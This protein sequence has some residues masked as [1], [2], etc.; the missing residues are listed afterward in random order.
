MTGQLQL[1]EI[2]KTFVC[3]KCGKADT[4][5][6]RGRT[7]KFC[8]ECVDN[9]AYTNYVCTCSRCGMT[10]E[11][12]S[13]NTHYCSDVCRNRCPDCGEPS[14]GPTSKCLKCRPDAVENCLHCEAP[15]EYAGVGRPPL[16]CNRT[17]ADR[18]RGDRTRKIYPDECCPWCFK[19]FAYTPH[20][21][22]C[23]NECKK[24]AFNHV[25]QHRTIDRCHLVVCTKCRNVIR[26]NGGRR[27]DLC[28][29]CKAKNNLARWKKKNAIRRGRIS[30]GDS[31]STE[32]LGDRDGWICWLCDGSIDPTIKHPDRRCATIDHVVPLNPRDG[33]P[34]GTHTW[35]NVRIAHLACNTA[36]GDRR[37]TRDEVA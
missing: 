18:A 10:F 3:Q 13:K 21:T 4:Q 29:D 1:F 12:S 23:S 34:A 14:T 2:D 16:Y 25:S 11:S 32:A 20:V 24:H 27:R 35:D 7:R 36:K 22:Y 31:I 15:I 8:Q 28:D 6:W 19:T 26:G 9:G 33:G 37:I 30:E 17:C 5:S